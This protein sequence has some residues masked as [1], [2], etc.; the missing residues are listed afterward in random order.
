M[1]DIIYGAGGHGRELAFQLGQI[2]RPVAC[3]IDDFSN[4]RV[5]RDIPVFSYPDARHLHHDATWHVAI[6]DIPVRN[7]LLEKLR[8]DGIKVGGFQSSATIAAPSAHIE[9]TAQ[10][11]GLSVISDGCLI[12]HDVIV[13]F[14]C[15]ISHDVGVGRG[16]IICPRVAIAGNVQIGSNVW[17]GVGCT[18]I[19][20]SRDRP[21]TIGNGAYVGA[22]SCVISD[23]AENA[24]VY[25][26]PAKARE[27]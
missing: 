26:V 1:S 8:N 2:S 20:G 18:I 4:A 11:F 7:K 19:N 22:G 14:G 23:V 5:E 16:S 12:G 9:P 17:L 13:N 25:G 21:I 24:L 6:G 27:S 10:V 3:F 15:I